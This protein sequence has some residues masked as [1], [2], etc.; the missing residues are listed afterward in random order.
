MP[1]SRM[2]LRGTSVCRV[3]RSPTSG[4]L[5][6]LD[7]AFASPGMSAL[8]E[9]VQ[10]WH[11]NAAWPPDTDLSEPWLRFSDHDPVVVDLLLR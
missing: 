5:G 1:D 6:T 2:W 4:Q 9:Q 11:V 10:V 3:I 7:Y 8:I